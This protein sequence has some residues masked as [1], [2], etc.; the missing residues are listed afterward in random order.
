MEVGTVAAVVWFT[1]AGLSVGLLAYAVA[2]YNTLVRLKHT[3][4][5]AWSNIDVLL[6]QRHSELP[7]LVETCKQF[8]RFEQETLERIMRARA[9]AHSARKSGDVKGVGDAESE[10]RAGL[11]GLFAVAEAYPQLETNEQYRKLQARISELE[12]AIADRREFYNDAVAN[13]NIRVEQFPDTVVARS[14][15]F[16]PATLLEFDDDETAD[17]ELGALFA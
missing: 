1:V 2:I 8:G 15:G 12:E 7:K 16:S 13:N 17:V 10:I 9:A 6:K 11:S 14:L 4:S 3:V 5:R